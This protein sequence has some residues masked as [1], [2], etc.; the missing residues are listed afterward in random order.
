ME[1][2]SMS[3]KEIE[4]IPIFED[5]KKKTIKQ[6]HAAQLLNLSIRQI[7][8]KLKNYRRFGAKSL[9]HAN[10][11][12]PGNRQFDS[13]I[14]EQ[15]LSLIE[16]YYPDFAP[17]FASEK[18]LENHNLLINR[19]TLRQKMIKGGLWISKAKKVTHHKWRERKACFGEL[20][21]LDGSPH[22][23]FED[24][25]PACCLLAFIDDS[26]SQILHLE[27][28]PEE[29]T[30]PVMKA[31]K[32]Y[33]ELYG[34]PLELYVD[35]G[36]VF[37]VNLNNPDGE[38]ITQYRRSLEELNIK[39]IY[40]RSPQAK[41]RVERLFGTLQ[42]RLVKELRLQ[43]ISAINVANAFLKDTF[44]PAFN[45]KFGV[46]PAKWADLHRPLTK[47]D[48]KN[49]DS[50]FSVH[51]TRV[52]MNDFTVQFKNQ[53]FQL[54]QQQPVI[55]CRKD[56]IMVEEHLGGSIKLKL[57]GKE[58][59]YTVLP[60]RPEKAYKLKIA[61]LTTGR[62]TYKPPANHPWRRQILLDTLTLQTTR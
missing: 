57:R 18:L 4:Q 1:T 58:L 54:N 49:L 45:E 29:A 53:Y 36:K 37:K 6:K 12:K 62:P 13:I 7:K 30:I 3:K 27:F 38:K 28:M 34:R 26:T 32:T 48:K 46:T 44:I 17:T 55:V 16:N 56:R 61:A 41:G 35:R 52:V 10:R 21:Q 40:A 23:W 22:K 42:D 39:V 19:E 15:A 59:Y 14:V 24:R 33:I 2:L 8:R 9:L 43:N 51:S 5:L 25:A 11:G 50:I 31:T 47:T 60:K 20:V